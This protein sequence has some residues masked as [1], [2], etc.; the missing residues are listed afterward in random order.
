MK[1]L[2]TGA[3]GFIGKPLYD[4]LTSLVLTN[5]YQVHC[6]S[7][8][9]ST[10]PNWYCVDL[11]DLKKVEEIIAS[12]QPDILIHLAWDVEHGKYWHNPNNEDYK[13]ASI[14]IFKSFI[15]NG[16]QKIIAA[17]TCAEYPTSDKSVAEDMS[18]DTDTLTPYGKAKRKVYDWLHKNARD[19]TASLRESGGNYV[20]EF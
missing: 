13:D 18:V 20:K 5:T 3:T 15:K 16:G 17:G 10:K 1:I 4:L 11:L 6:I 19:F 8:Q 7:R 2:L 9:K 14:H 12:I